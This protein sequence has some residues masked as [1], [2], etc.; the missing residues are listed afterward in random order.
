VP[1]Q[2]EVKGPE[3]AAQRAAPPNVDWEKERQAAARSV[4]Q[5]QGRPGTSLDGSSEKPRPAE[6]VEPATTAL[7]NDGCVIAKNRAQRFTARLMGRCVR[8][9]R[10]DMFAAIMPEYLKVRPV[11]IETHPEA[12]GSVLSDGTEISTVKCELVRKGAP[13][14]LPADIP[15]G[16]ASLARA[17]AQ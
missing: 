2:P 1:P 13:E 4:V 16:D 17:G 14:P 12:P 6:P 15:G 5:Q 8:G 7:V 9:P 3:A 10:G 11:C